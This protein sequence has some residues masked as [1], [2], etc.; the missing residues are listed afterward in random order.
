MKKIFYLIILLCVLTLSCVDQN[1][2]ETTY[3]L[4]NNSSKDIKIKPYSR[5]RVDGVLSVGS[6][7]ADVINI[8]SGEEKKIS[9]ELRDS[10]TFY[11]IKNIDSVRIIFDNQK[12]LVFVCNDWPEMTTCNTI[13]R[14]DSNN[15]HII[16]ENDYNSAEDCNGNCD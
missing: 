8:N 1:I 4:V 2:P 16:T 5:N 13:F 12:L 3:T 7:N 10:K 6:I 11:S 9:R 15:S 14:G